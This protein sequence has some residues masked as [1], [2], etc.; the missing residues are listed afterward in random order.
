M[1]TQIDTSATIT[2]PAR[3]DLL[4]GMGDFHGHYPA[5]ET[6]LSSL[7]AEY[8]IFEDKQKLVMGKNVTLVCTGD[9]ID[10]GSSALK[11]I[12]TFKQLARKN[13]QRVVT[14]TGNHELMA[15][16]DLD[17]ARQVLKEAV[18]K[19]ANEYYHRYAAYGYGGSFHGY[20]GGIDFIQEFG[21]NP[22][23][24]LRNYVRRMSKNGD[25][26]RW[27]R[28]LK[29]CA[30]MDFEGTKVLFTH[31]D[32]PVNAGTASSIRAFARQYRE[33]MRNDSQVLGG[34]QKKYGDEAVIKGRTIFWNREFSQMRPEDID[35]MVANLGVDYL[36]VGH[37][38]HS[39]ITLYSQKALDI[40]VG[41]T[42]RYGENEP[43]ALVFKKDGIYGF[44]ARSGEKKLR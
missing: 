38:P 34:T 15:L 41:M 33:H 26:G 13:R 8:R 3:G 20:N 2:L 16:A 32:V 17:Y 42:P 19:D 23:G 43:A 24:A 37:T 10:R 21:S 29:P 7:D 40:D 30:L 36:V 5:L 6:L 14:L 35:Q 28:K 4:I 18:P 22:E 1:T 39:G 25:I 9:Y 12:D 44:Y 11:I 31:A 27:L